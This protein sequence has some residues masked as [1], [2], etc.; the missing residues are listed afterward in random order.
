MTMTTV[1]FTSMDDATQEEMELIA[2]EAA[3]HRSNHLLPNIVSLLTAMSGNT[4]GYQ[5]DRLEHSLQSATRAHREGARVDMVVAALLHDMG[6][7]F[8]PDNHS[9]VAA[10]ILKP[11][12]DEEAVWVVKHHG[13]FQSYHYGDAM[14]VP[15]DGRDIY[16]DSPYFDTCAH[17]CAAWDSVSFDPNYDSLPLEFFMP[18]LEEVFSRE[19]QA[20]S[21]PQWEA[22]V[23]PA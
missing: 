8:A 12:L 21:N 3:T 5:V 13:L 1:N 16:R 22:A 18:M 11:F 17:F 9:E 19:P 20:F 6:D 2:S 23:E 10:A 4:F 14:G 7:D 15:K